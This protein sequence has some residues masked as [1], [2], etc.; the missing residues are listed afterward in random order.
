MT[1]RTASI[2]AKTLT[3]SSG[4]VMGLP[5]GVLGGAVIAG[6]V[7]GLVYTL[8]PLSIWFVLAAALLMS[9]ARRGLT[10]RERRWVT[11]VMVAALAARIGFVVVLLLRSPHD[12]Q[13]ALML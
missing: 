11:A 7:L 10:D 5:A 4:T 6:T 12:S 13:G 1:V 2:D 3:T 9:L 8:S